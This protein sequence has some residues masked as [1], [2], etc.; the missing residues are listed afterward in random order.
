VLEEAEGALPAELAAA[1][2]GVST[3]ANKPLRVDAEED[4]KP[5]TMQEMEQEANWLKSFFEDANGSK[6]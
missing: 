6:D 3:N 4:R 5:R 2:A 1:H